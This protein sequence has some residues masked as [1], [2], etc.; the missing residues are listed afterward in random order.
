MT[1]KVV[2]MTKIVEQVT[3]LAASPLYEYRTQNKYYPVIGEGS[4]DA[5]IMFVGEAPG[6]NEAK[7]GKPFCGSAGKILDELELELIGLI[8]QFL[9]VMIL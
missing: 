2:E 1:S 3:N 7:T 9:L 8:Y 5:K 6:R 4:L